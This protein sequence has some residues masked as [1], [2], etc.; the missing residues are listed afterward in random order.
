MEKNLQ[1]VNRQE[2]LAVWSERIAAC[3]SSGISVRAWCE[4]IDPRTAVTSVG[5]YRIHPFTNLSF[6]ITFGIVYFKY[7]HL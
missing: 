4:R 5:G 2:K 6:L 1:T 3:R 7:F